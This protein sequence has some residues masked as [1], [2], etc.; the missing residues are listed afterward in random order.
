MI[1]HCVI[2][3]TIGILRYLRSKFQHLGEGLLTVTYIAMK[4]LKWRHT[5]EPLATID[6]LEAT[7]MKSL[8]GQLT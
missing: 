7:E 3:E 5:A 6:A 8:H 4:R 1:Q 2:N